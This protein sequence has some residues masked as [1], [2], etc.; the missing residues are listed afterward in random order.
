M[1]ASNEDI[2]TSVDGG[3]STLGVYAAK[4]PP[5]DEI[6]NEDMDNL[7][8]AAEIATARIV[9]TPLSD[10]F[11][12]EVVDAPR[13]SFHLPDKGKAPASLAV[14]NPLASHTSNN[15]NAYVA[16]NC[17]RLYQ[18]EDLLPYPEIRRL[19]NPPAHR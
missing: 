9:V 8:F 4:T 13:I 17:T 3:V 6:S 15:R 11:P 2:L 18:I 7:T 1:D 14:V 10:L 19:V 5:E 12:R 16:T